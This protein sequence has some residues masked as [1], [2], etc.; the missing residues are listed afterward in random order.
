MIA[1]VTRGERVLTA[2]PW[3][4]DGQ[5][6]RYGIG[7][8][9]QVAPRVAAL[10][11]E[12]H[13]EGTRTYGFQDGSDVMLFG[14]LDEIRAENAIQISRNEYL[15]DPDTGQTQIHL[16]SPAIGGFVPLG[17][18]RDGHAHPHAGTG[19]GLGQAHLLPADEHGGFVWGDE[20]RRDLLEVFQFSFEADTFES[21]RSHTGTQDSRSPLAIGDSGWCIVSHG[22]TTAIPDGD[23]LLLTVLA[24]KDDT[25]ACGIARW[26]CL[27]RV[28]RPVSFQSV[29][30]GESVQSQ[31][32]YAEAC[33]WLEPSLIRDV[34]G[35]LLFAARGQDY[36]TTADGVALG[37]VIRVWRST[38][39]GGHGWE[40]VIDVPEARQF[41]PMT[42]NQA[43][44]GTP[45]IVSTP[46]DHSFVF[47][48]S[49]D[50]DLAAARMRGRGRE[51]LC[52]WALNGERSVLESPLVI[53][54]ADA[55]FGKR[56]VD[57]EWYDGWMVDHANAC[58]VRLSDGAWHNVLVYRGLHSALYHSLGRY[59]ASQTG[60]YVEEVLSDGP[61]LPVWDFED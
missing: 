27:D 37:K 56:P 9:F 58:T 53:R 19:F 35:S 54:D 30:V 17:A 1:G 47:K 4:R 28:W 46:Y 41:A 61:A 11:V 15:D 3:Q 29:A 49:S 20:D 60:C 57:P 39:G 40:V 18:T 16:K 33:S 38:D 22:L 43:A 32:N 5:V 24:R 13:A 55:D 52:V 12:A 25:P 45:Y 2:P 8:P 44:D 59:P 21:R 48:L 10:L 7:F 50:P 31:A 6:I 36:G 42:I 14:S 51:I 34:D 23:D 26:S